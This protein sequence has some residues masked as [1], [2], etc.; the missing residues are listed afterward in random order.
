[1]RATCGTRR[2]LLALWA[3]SEA[4]FCAHTEGSAI[5]RIGHE[6][7]RR[8]LAVALGNALARNRRRRRIARRCGGAAD[9]PT[10]LLREH[11]DWALAPAL[12][13]QR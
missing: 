10:P 6:R 9:A 3:W 2:E 13:A 5:R 7:W 4:E 1:M 8:N 12:S 11:I